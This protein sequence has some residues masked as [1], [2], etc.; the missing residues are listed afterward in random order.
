MD[1]ISLREVP[2]AWQYRREFNANRTLRG[3]N[4]GGYDTGR[5]NETDAVLYRALSARGEIKYTV[6]SYNTVIA[7]VTT[8][9]VEFKTTER[10]SVTTSRHQSRLYG[11]RDDVTHAP[12]DEQRTRRVE[13]FVRDVDTLVDAMHWTPDLAIPRV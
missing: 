4:G 10:F 6:K 1:I 12:A 13:D 3:L 9:D 11:H 7:W 2:T 5:L 8:D